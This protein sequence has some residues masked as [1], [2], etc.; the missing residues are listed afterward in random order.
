M[1]VCVIGA[2]VTGL[3]VA[4]LLKHKH[5]VTVLEKDVDIGGIART[6]SVDGVS[7]HMVGGHCFNSK[8]QE[9][10]DFVFNEVMP[11]SDWHMVKREA[12]IYFKKNIIS[13]PIEFSIKEIAGF[14]TDLAFNITKDFLSGDAGESRNLGEWFKSNFGDTLAEEYFIPYNRKIWDMDPY[15][16]SPAWVKGKLPQPNKKEFFDALI[17]SQEDSMPHGRFY[18]PNANNQNAFIEALAKD[19]N[20][21]RNFEVLKI[22]KTN[23]GW[24]INDDREFDLVISTAPLNALPFI[25]VDTPVAIQSL[26]KK[27]KYNKVTTMLWRTTPLD[28]T[29]SYF[30]D[31]DTIFHRHIHIGNFFLPK[32]NFT[33]TES[34]GEHSYEEMVEHGRKVDY[35]LEPLDYNVSDYAYV[36]YDENYIESTEK[37]KEYIG[38]IGLHSIGRFGEWEYFN[39]DICIESAMRLA[40]KIS[41]S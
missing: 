12:K 32:K 7:Y 25:Y 19:L 30:P 40:N 13:Y 27:L 8:N 31:S 29:W 41:Q 15:K 4:R 28:P 33:I 11:I 39:M 21:E 35:L 38:S 1:D 18:Y 6:R 24:L 16:M 5:N 17:S 3:A 26:A 14:D 37:I 20:I 23:R 22:E 36:V 2:G 9:V 10:L 34:V